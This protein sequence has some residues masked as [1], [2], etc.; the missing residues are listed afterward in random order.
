VATPEQEVTNVALKRDRET[1]TGLA[2][3]GGLVQ[4]G[5]V[6]F[7]VLLAN[8]VGQVGPATE[9][10]APPLA[11]VPLASLV[12]SAREVTALAFSPDGQVLAVGGEE[13]EVHL[14]DVVRKEKR[15]TLAPSDRTDALA[16]SPD[17]KTLA[18]AGE[19]NPIRLWDVKTGKQVGDLTIKGGGY[20]LAVAWSSDGA[21]L[22]AGTGTGGS[23]EVRVWNVAAR[24]AVVRYEGPHDW[25]RAVAFGPKDATV[26]FAGQEGVGL[27]T[28]LTS[29]K[30]VRDLPALAWKERKCEHAAV[31]PD[32]KTFAL[33][34]PDGV[35]LGAVGSKDRP[36]VLER[37]SQA[38]ALAFR[39]DGKVLAA[40]GKGQIKL[41]DVASGRLLR[42]LRHGKGEVQALAFS[43]NGALL[44]SGSEEGTVRLWRVAP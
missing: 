36:R 13:R 35:L 38:F 5:G 18:S 23:S 20:N 9:A 30:R 12:C 15:R 11:E 25:M 27:I 16:F 2:R 26:L 8:S 43:P 42:V 44:A 4:A 28:D 34:T 3:L 17:G 33:A 40:G 1:A 24:K 29:A 22:V 21:L 19:A 41:Y 14:W 6:L 32:G 10:A 39:P 37:M 31:R 7:A